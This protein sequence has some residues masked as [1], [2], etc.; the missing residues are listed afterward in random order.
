MMYCMPATQ[1]HFEEDREVL[2]HFSVEELADKARYC[3][4]PRRQPARAEVRLR[5]G[6]RV[7]S[8]H[9]WTHRF[10]RIFKRLSLIR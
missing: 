1:T 8:E 9:T 5:A 7:L 10:S 2:Y 3:L 6:E 4:D